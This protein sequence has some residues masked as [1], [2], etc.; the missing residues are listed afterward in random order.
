MKADM[1]IATQLQEDAEPKPVGELPTGTKLSNFD[2]L[3]GILRKRHYYAFSLCSKTFR[4]ALENKLGLQMPI[5]PPGPNLNIIQTYRDAS[6]QTLLSKT[7][8]LNI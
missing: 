3:I 1:Y 2:W 6:T 5:Y 7:L 8:H 4:S